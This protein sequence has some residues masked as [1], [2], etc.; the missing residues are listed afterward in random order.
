MALFVTDP[1][2]EE[3]LLAQRRAFGGDRFDEVWDGVYFMPPL[4]ND[5][6]QSLGTRLAA[7]VLLILGWDGP[8]HVYAGVNVSDREED[9]ESNYRCPDVAVFL[10]GTRAKDCGTH[11]CGGADFIIEITSPNDR[12]REK[13]P[14]YAL[15]GVKE[16]LILD[17]DPWAL[18]LYQ[19]QNGQLALTA[20]TSLRQSLT[21]QVLGVQFS[22]QPGKARPLVEVVHPQ[23][24]Q[25]WLV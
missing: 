18:E 13:L 4:A 22:L 17:R 7:V 2:V 12:T 21:S 19:L 24:G 20:R 15:L 5:E 23:S 10:H 16:L 3:R 25:R 1:D 8:N 9:W 14:F 6:H 11:W